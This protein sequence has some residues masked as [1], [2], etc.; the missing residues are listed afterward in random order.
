MF[1]A[2][3]ES[4]SVVSVS[5]L[6]NSTLLNITDR[7]PM[8]T[9]ALNYSR[10]LLPKPFSIFSADK[11]VVFISN[12][13]HVTNPTVQFSCSNRWFSHAT[14]NIA[15]ALQF[16]SVQISSVQFPY[17][18]GLLWAALSCSGL[19]RAALG[20]FG[21]LRAALGCSLL[22]TAPVCSELL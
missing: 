21:L 9:Y 7:I 16:S 8:N 13:R 5:T 14:P 2:R 19:L 4:A 15:Q 17:S 18:S 12:I 11:W 1:V 6:L 3:E 10:W 20:C 22:C